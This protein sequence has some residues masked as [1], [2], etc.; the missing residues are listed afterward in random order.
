MQEWYKCPKCNQDII[1]GTNPCPNCKSS[2]AWSQ[3]GPVLYLPP[4]GIPQQ[5]T[6]QKQDVAAPVSEKSNIFNPTLNP[7]KTAIG[8]GILIIVALVIAVIIGTMPKSN[9]TSES[10]FID[11]KSSVSFDGSQFTISNNDEFDWLNVK[12]EL[13]SPAGLSGS[14]YKLTYPRIVAGQTYTVGAMQFTKED[15]TRFNPF[16]TKPLTIVIICDT[17]NGKTGIGGGNWK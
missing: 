14:G 17:P 11:L 10:S 16:T 4:I 3:Q 2:L 8:C 1:F 15:G 6:I 13:N 5:Q 12:F 7:K 9:T